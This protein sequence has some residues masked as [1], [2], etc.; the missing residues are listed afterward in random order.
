M[1]D[2]RFADLRS[3]LARLIPDM[4][5]SG[6]KPQP[7]DSETGPELV[8]DEYVPAAIVELSRFLL[9][10]ELRIMDCEHPALSSELYHAILGTLSRET[11]GRLRLVAAR[12]LGER[13]LS[14]EGHVRTLWGDGSV[15]TS[16]RPPPEMVHR[17]FE[18]LWEFL[19]SPDTDADQTR[20]VLES[21]EFYLSLIRGHY[22]YFRA[23]ESPATD[24]ASLKKEIDGQIK[25]LRKIVAAAFRKLPAGDRA[26]L[27]GRFHLIFDVGPDL[28]DEIP[29]RVI[30]HRAWEKLIAELV[31]DINADDKMAYLRLFSPAC[32][33]EFAR[34]I[35]NTPARSL[36]EFVFGT[37][38]KTVAIQSFAPGQ[39]VFT[40]TTDLGSRPTAWGYRDS[41]LMKTDAGW[42]LEPDLDDAILFRSLL[43]Q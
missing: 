3:S 11:D 17:S 21:N 2:P 16:L 28:R 15:H 37:G 9:D 19:S 10:A 14:G 23:W 36:A 38:A 31:K 30:R 27:E 43:V 22:L 40:V 7:Q 5:A 34:D 35:A 41:V 20:A 13:F 33:A 18:S 29:E 39:V 32:R 1:A 25:E 4:S 6:G 26:R 12:S 24:E 8:D 42:A